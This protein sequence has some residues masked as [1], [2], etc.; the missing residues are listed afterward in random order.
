VDTVDRIENLLKTA[1]Q[2]RDSE[3]WDH[4]L[5]L[6]AE[7][8]MLSEQAG[9][10]PGIPRSLALQA[11]VHYI[12]SDLRT[13][14]SECIKALHLAAGD[15]E[16]ECRARSVLAMVHWSLGNYEEALKNGER[17]IELLDVI[18]DKVTKAFA[19]AVKGGI[20]LSLGQADDALLWH[21]RSIEAFNS[22]PEQEVGRARALSG[23]G[24]TYVAQKRYEEALTALLEALQ[25]A[26]RVN[27]RITTARTL[28]DLGEVFEALDN[29]RQ[30]LEYHTEAL[31]IRQEDGYRQAETTSLLALGRISARRCDYGPAIEFLTRGLRIAEE[32][33]IR[34]RI[35]QFHHALADVY[36][37]QGQLAPALDHFMTFDKVRSG[38]DVDQATL[39]YKAVVFE[40]QLETMQRTAEL[41]TLASLGGLVAAI[42]H[43]INT[44]LGAI[45]SSADVAIKAADR[46]LM[47]HDVK[48]AAVLR[49]NARV[50][51]DASL[52]ISE[53][54]KRL[55]LIG[56]IDQARYSRIDLVSAVEDVVALLRPEFE[57]RVTVSIE[58]DDVPPIYA[59]AT[60]LYQV[61]LNLLRNSVKA[62]EDAGTVTVRVA[63][64]E[65]WFRVSFIDS[66]RGIPEP[67]VHQVFSPGFTSDSG[68]VR[69]SLS[70]F[71]C[72]LV[73]KKH[74]GDIHVESEVGRGST[75]TLLLPR[76]LEKSNAELE[77]GKSLQRVPS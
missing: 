30:A 10:A 35:A 64:D 8:R 43:E 11:F 60:E 21:Q 31:A 53:L 33:E 18:G 36:H 61:F 41:E 24:L 66:G 37:R 2:A 20:L 47:S 19:F 14:L 50:I 65:H 13:A 25:L 15:A 75:F 69:A 49:S 5:E 63:G 32:L 67:L 58:H 1:W 77:A 52:R 34:P 6:A 23:L 59:Y 74:G 62:I 3:Q 56:G 9:F 12:R 16:A 51:A 42:A 55:K 26:R 39:R 70:L 76:L 38:L 27:H 68:R 46:L 22:M 57:P 29:D 17:A 73:A 72:L 71:T 7:A 48:A 45:Q 4:M 40:S 44:P 28:S 54:V